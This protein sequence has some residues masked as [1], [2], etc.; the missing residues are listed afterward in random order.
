MAAELVVQKGADKSN[1]SKVCADF[2]KIIHDNDI[3]D[4]VIEFER[5]NFNDWLSNAPETEADSQR[6]SGHAKLFGCL[7]NVGLIDSH[8]AETTLRELLKACCFRK[9]GDTPC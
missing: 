2:V 6:C 1:F 8:D 4:N 3:T 5:V 9:H 7:A